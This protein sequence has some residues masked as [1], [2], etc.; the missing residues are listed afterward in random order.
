M[1]LLPRNL[2]LYTCLKAQWSLYLSI[3]F[4]YFICLF[5]LLGSCGEK[6][7]FFKEVSIYSHQIECLRIKEI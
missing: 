4:S 7:F 2:N 1:F 5:A 3:I 6:R